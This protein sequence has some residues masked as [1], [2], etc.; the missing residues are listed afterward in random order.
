MR[1]EV[2][3][4]LLHG[5]LHLYGMDHEVD[6]GEMAARESELRGQ[7][8]L[9]NGLI[10]RVESVAGREAGSSAAPR[11]DNQKSKSNGKGK[12]NS[13][14]NGNGKGSKKKAVGTKLV[15]SRKKVSA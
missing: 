11:N 5:L 9:R 8:R 15:R 1:D 4:L 7:L 13:N 2:R 3:V 10:A 14:G 6:D 12:N